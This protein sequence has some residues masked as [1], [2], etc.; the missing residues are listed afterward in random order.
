MELKYH[1]MN[2]SNWF[3]VIDE[4][5]DSTNSILNKRIAVSII[6]NCQSRSFQMNKHQSSVSVDQSYVT[7]EQLKCQSEQKQLLTQLC[8]RSNNEDVNH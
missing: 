6:A 8:Q 4:Q 7:I 2:Q 3:V 5:N 1:D